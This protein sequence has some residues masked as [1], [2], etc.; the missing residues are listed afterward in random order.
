MKSFWIATAACAALAGCASRPPGAS[1]H[2]QDPLEG[3]NRSVSAFNDALDAAVLE[4]AARGWRAAVPAPVRTGVSNVFAN[5]G[6]VW[7]GINHLLQGQGERAYR[8]LVRFTTN[9]VLGLGGVLDIASAAG[10]ERE[11]QDFGQTLAHWGVP[12][13]PYL[14]LPVLG[15]STLRDTAALPVDFNGYAL[16][17][18]HPV[19]HRNTL[20]ATRLIDNRAQL[21]GV[22]ATL[23]AV[24]LDKYSL[25]REFHLNQRA[26]LAS[27]TAEEL[28]NA[29]RVESYDDEPE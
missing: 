7:S 18:L 12:A 20:T 26:R 28:A 3:M 1:P 16:A 24:A 27:P 13:G 23:D 8:H 10:I 17:H 9:T 22:T 21:L 6:D 11:R 19:A 14:V 29:G 25:V 5:V 4:P 15:P 2:A